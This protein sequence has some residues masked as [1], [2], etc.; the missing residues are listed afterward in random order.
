ML[1]PE[2]ARRGEV[3]NDELL[4]L[5]E[6][7]GD[8]GVDHSGSS[9][10]RPRPGLPVSRRCQRQRCQRAFRATYLHAGK[11]RVGGGA[12]EGDAEGAWLRVGV[13]VRV[14]VGIGSGLGLGVGVGI[15]SGLGLGLGAGS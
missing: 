9:R 3:L 14:G 11:R 7:S 4:Q 15:G 10:H 2:A 5:P 8:G 12:G 1:L 6:G 13:G